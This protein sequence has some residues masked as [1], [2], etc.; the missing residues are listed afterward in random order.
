MQHKFLLE[1]LLFVSFVEV[2]KED[3]FRPM[4]SLMNDLGGATPLV[5][6]MGT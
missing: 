1:Q 3:C 6:Y 4:H 2:E 5:R